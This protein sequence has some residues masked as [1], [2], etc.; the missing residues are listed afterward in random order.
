[1]VTSWLTATLGTK[2]IEQELE[3]LLSVELEGDDLAEV[4]GVSVKDLCKRVAKRILRDRGPGQGA[5]DGVDRRPELLLDRLWS[6]SAS[7]ATAGI[8]R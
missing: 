4:S 3:G 2:L 8:V 1:M 7:L 6:G 5:W